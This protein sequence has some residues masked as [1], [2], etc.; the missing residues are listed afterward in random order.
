MTWSR[1]GIAYI[2]NQQ[3][4]PE[5]DS[6][7]SG[8]R[9]PFGKV[10]IF[11]GMFRAPVPEPDTSIDIVEPAR[12]VHPVITRNLTHPVFVVQERPKDTV[13]LRLCRKHAPAF[14]LQAADHRIG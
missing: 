4:G 8:Y 9:V 7:E 2:D 5:A 12:Y 10:N 3:W 6:I 14:Q 1:R 13:V 11:I